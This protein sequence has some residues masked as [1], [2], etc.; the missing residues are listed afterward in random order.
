MTSL[1][2]SWRRTLPLPSS[3]PSTGPT[4]AGKT[5]RTIFQ[6]CKNHVEEN[7]TI[8]VQRY[9]SRLLKAATGSFSPLGFRLTLAT[10]Q[11]F[12]VKFLAVDGGGDGIDPI[13]G[14]TATKQASNCISCGFKCL[15]VAEIRYEEINIE[16]LRNVCARSRCMPGFE[17]VSQK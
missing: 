17:S 16:V 3:W 11:R 9:L 12:Q 7:K 6:I 15:A 14:K 13:V 2:N 1:K 5:H 4:A 10:P 8:S